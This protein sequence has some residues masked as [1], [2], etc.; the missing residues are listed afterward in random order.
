MSLEI[1]TSLSE[2]QKAIWTDAMVYNELTD[3]D[4]L[5]PAPAGTPAVRKRP[6]LTAI[7]W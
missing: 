4:E 6:P 5:R 7:G 3:V 1:V 2:Q